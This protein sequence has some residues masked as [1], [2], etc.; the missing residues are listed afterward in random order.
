MKMNPVVHFEM[1]SNDQKRVSEFYATVFG[2]KMEHMDAQYGGYVVATTTEIGE[3]GR[4]KEAGAINGG[5]YKLDEKQK[6]PVTSVVIS[7]DNIDEHAKK[8]TAAGGTLLGEPMQIPGVGK[9]VAFKD[10]EGN[11]VGMLQPEMNS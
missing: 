11:Q 4:P 9:Y 3:N 10:T 7:V 8:V 1:P 2:W 5:F 6:N